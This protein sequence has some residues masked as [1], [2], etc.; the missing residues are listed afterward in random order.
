MGSRKDTSHTARTVV[1]SFPF[2]IPTMPLNSVETGHVGIMWNGSFG[3]PHNDDAIVDL[4]WRALHLTTVHAKELAAELYGRNHT[5]SYFSG[6]ST[7]GRQGIKAMV[8]F[9]EDYDGLLYVPYLSPPTPPNADRV[10]M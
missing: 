2:L 7:G 10:F 1:R 6:C 9:P 3:G 4:A 5:K 8:A